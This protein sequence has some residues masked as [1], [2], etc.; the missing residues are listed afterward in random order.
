MES[1][2][3]NLK[4]Y[5]AAPYSMKDVIKERAAEL[6]AAGVEVTSRWLEEPHRPTTQLHELTREDHQFYALQDVEDVRNADILVFQTDETKTI[7]RAGRHVEFGIAIGIALERAFF[8]IF[9]VGQD[10]E[11]IFHYLPQVTHF[12]SWEVVKNYLISLVLVA[13]D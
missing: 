13:H 6:R 12:E 4:A 10:H 5:L 3:H 2:M 7:I 11:N 8:P 9:V 1:T